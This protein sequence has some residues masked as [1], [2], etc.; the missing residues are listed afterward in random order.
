[1]KSN[2]K[3]VQCCRLVRWF[4]VDRHWALTHKTS[5]QFSALSFGVFTVSPYRSRSGL[6]FLRSSFKRPI[7][8]V[9]VLLEVC[10]P[11]FF[12]QVWADVPAISAIFQLLSNHFSKVFP[13]F[14]CIVWYYYTNVVRHLVLVI[15]LSRFLWKDFLLLVFS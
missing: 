15:F 3:F 14:S 2:D 7:H 9:L 5:P 6:M 8:I 10:A 4:N 11:F 1:M 13:F 12:Y